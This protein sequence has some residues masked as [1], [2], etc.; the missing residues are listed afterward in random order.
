[1]PATH[2]A[3]TEFNKEG[4]TMILNDRRGTLFDRPHDLVGLRPSSQH[5][6]KEVKTDGG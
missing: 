5:V 4:R 1:M 3:K 2:L 6:S